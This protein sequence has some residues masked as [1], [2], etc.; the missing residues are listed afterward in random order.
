MAV[1]VELVESKGMTRLPGAQAQVVE[2]PPL[3]VSHLTAAGTTIFI[4]QAKLFIVTNRGQDISIRISPIAD[5]TAAGPTD[6]LSFVLKADESFTFGLP[7]S[8]DPTQYHMVI[9]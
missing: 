5:N 1:S 8:A 3:R 7:K 9:A 6:G 2:M 4:D